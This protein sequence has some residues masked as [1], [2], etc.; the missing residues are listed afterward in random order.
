MITKELY[1]LDFGV[2][3]QAVVVHELVFV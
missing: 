1:S 3:P 2:L